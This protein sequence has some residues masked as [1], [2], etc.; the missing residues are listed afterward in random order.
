MDENTIPIEA[1]IQDR[2]IDSG[3]GCY[4]GQEVIVRI[5]DRGHVNRHLRQ[6]M[7]GH[8]PTP[9]KGT[10]LFEEGSEKAAGVVTSAVQSPRFGQ[11]VALG[12]VK[13]G[14]TGPIRAGGV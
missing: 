13:R 7:L 4:T 14:V 6:I 12:Y 9:A 10:E 11:T 8:A 5:R 2:A 3:K 1:G